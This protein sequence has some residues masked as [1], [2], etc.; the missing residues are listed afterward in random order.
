MDRLKLCVYPR[1]KSLAAVVV[2][3]PAGSGM[4]PTVRL[5]I[6]MAG[7]PVGS[8][9]EGPSVAFVPFKLTNGGKLFGPLQS[10]MGSAGGAHVARKT[11][12][13]GGRS[14]PTTHPTP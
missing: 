6:G 3:T 11:S 2:P 9:P 14:A 7:M 13:C 5:G 1:R 12:H 4:V 8:V 10:Q